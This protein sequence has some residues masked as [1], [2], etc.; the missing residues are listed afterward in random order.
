[1]GKKTS[2]YLDDDLAAAVAESGEGIAVLIR[3]GLGTEA[4]TVAS[5][6]TAAAEAV[7][8]ALAE[9]LRLIVRQEVREALGGDCPHPPARVLKGL[10]GAC[11]E[12]VGGS[13]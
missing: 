1:M 10:C 4:V 11:G 13:R 8:A 3:R 6:A 7:R 2:V 12:H 5:A 9:D